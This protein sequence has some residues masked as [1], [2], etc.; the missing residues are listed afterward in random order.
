ML[1]PPSLSSARRSLE[2]SDFAIFRGRPGD[3]GGEQGH[4]S[5]YQVVA[6]GGIEETT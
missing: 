2:R 5:R 6:R 1:S 4:F 3:R